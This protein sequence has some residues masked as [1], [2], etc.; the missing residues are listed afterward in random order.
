MRR[1][2]IPLLVLV[3]C[4]FTA[5][6]FAAPVDPVADPSGYISEL[7]A[8]KAQGWGVL[9]LVG[10]FGLCEILAAAGKNGALAWLGKGRISILIGAGVAVSTAAIVALSS[11]GTWFAAGYAAVGAVL[12]YLHPAAK[13]VAIEQVARSMK[14]DA[15]SGAIG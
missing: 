13:D 14:A 10:V 9:L 3:S 8:A 6:A 2:L 5:V 11:S 7:A 1:I 15:I 4:T 12:L